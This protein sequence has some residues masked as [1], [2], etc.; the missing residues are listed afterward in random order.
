MLQ[1]GSSVPHRLSRSHSERIGMSRF[2][3]N[4]SAPIEDISRA[5]CSSWYRDRYEQ[6]DLYLIQDTSDFNAVNHR[7]RLRGDDP[8][9]GP[10]WQNHTLQELGFFMHPCLVV[11]AGSNFP[12]GYAHI[13]LWNRHLGEPD[14]IARNY[15]R[16]PIEEKSSYRWIESMQGGRQIL[17][18]HRAQRYHIMDR[19]ADIYELFVRPRAE[20]EHVIIRTNRNRSIYT[21]AGEKKNLWSYLDSR[22]PKAVIAIELPRQGKRLVRQAKMALYYESLSIA[23][24]K[25]RTKAQ[26][27][28]NWSLTLVQ[29]KELPETVPTGEHPV[30]WCLWTDL[31]IGTT[32]QALACIQAYKS[33]WIIEELFS[34][35][36]TKGLDAEA[37]QLESGLALKKLALLTLQ[38]ALYILQ[39]IK[40]RDNAYEQPITTILAE[41]DLAFLEALIRSLEGKTQKQQNPHPPDSLARLAWAVARLGGWSGYSSQSPPGP[42]TM[43]WGW[44]RFL[45][46]LQG[47]QLAR[48]FNSS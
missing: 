38:A 1:S 31:E 37:A 46:A 39:L 43:R 26:G 8:D 44:Q 18:G 10:L 25:D 29:V 5:I 45:R 16:Q 2:F 33:R 41:Q 42:K 28:D 32:E 12:L 27:P 19:E 13:H 11:A 15:K 24:P 7:G 3:H 14:R 40:D 17:A 6:E 23:R 30:H 22:R 48:Q 4:D 35:V 9:L 47:W 34:L 21:Q 20:N 36:K